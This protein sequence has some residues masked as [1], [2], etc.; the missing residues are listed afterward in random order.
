MNTVSI[1]VP[2]YNSEKYLPQCIES[3][4]N[5]T[6]KNFELILVNDGSTDNSLSICESYAQKD[7]KIEI[8]NLQHNGVSNARNNGISKAKGEFICFVDSDDKIE[9]DFLLVLTNLQNKYN[10]DIAEVDFKYLNDNSKKNTDNKEEVFNS[11]QMM[12]RLYST[13]GIRTVMI[14][15]KL[16]KASLFENILFDLEHEHED[17]FIIHKLIF[18]AKDNIAVSNLKLYVYRI[19]KKSRQRTFNTRKLDVLQVFDE[20]EKYFKEKEELVEKN[21]IA[22]LDM[23]L[24]LYSVC[25][26]NKKKK[27]QI[28]LKNIFEKEYE[29][30]NLNINLK[31]KIKYS[32]FEKLPNLVSNII[33]FKRGKFM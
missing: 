16:Y 17:E 31:R 10:S 26:L 24:F 19:H 27:E 21:K 28:Y 1:I 9:K 6:Y 32:L 30:F 4:L 25:K 33:I 8:L 22:K 14:P 13:N 15:N 3:I 2:I 7:E 5:Q 20:R 23:I 11:F 12:N 18:S 29:T